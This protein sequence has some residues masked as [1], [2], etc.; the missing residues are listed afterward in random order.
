MHPQREFVDRL[1]QATL[2]QD[3]WM[4]P[5]AELA[6]LFERCRQASSRLPD[7]K[8]RRPGVGG[9]LGVR[10]AEG[11]RDGDQPL[12]RAVVK[13]ALDPSSFVLGRLDDARA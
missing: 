12:L 13:I 3:P 8:P 7:Q 1:A 2:G 10:Q 4:D 5:L 11:H 6:K 9:D